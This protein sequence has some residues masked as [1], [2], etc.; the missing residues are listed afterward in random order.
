MSRRK[1]AQS[2]YRDENLPRHQSLFVRQAESLLIAAVRSKAPQSLAAAES[3]FA[4]YENGFP[5]RA[6]EMVAC[7][8]ML[9][10]AQL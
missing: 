1:K 10:S 6:S 4:K 3:A 5:H 9:E 7:N 2:S 8:F